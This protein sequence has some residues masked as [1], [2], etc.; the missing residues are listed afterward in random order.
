MSRLD[1]FGEPLDDDEAQPSLPFAGEPTPYGVAVPEHRPPPLCCE[2]CRTPLLPENY[3]GWCRECSLIVSARLRI[4]IEE[5]WRDLGDGEH[6]VSERGRIARLL[7]VDRCIDTRGCPS[8]A[9]RSTSTSWSRGPGAAPGQTGLRPAT[10]TTIRST[11]T[12][13]ISDGERRRRTP[14]TPRGIELRLP[15]GSREGETT[16]SGRTSPTGERNL[17]GLRAGMARRGRLVDDGGQT[18]VRAGGHRPRAE[19]LLRG[20]DLPGVPRG[21]GDGRPMSGASAIEQTWNRRTAA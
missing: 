21:G 13:R 9:K 3:T 6:V 20:P 8:P 5:P 18:S 2:L 19:H 4:P 15:R 1:R 14:R 7:N 12:R 17:L 16:M 10:G 11:R